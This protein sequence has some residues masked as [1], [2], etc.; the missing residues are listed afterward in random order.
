M[1]GF[2]YLTCAFLAS[3]AF[4][5]ELIEVSLYTGVPGLAKLGESYTTVTTNTKHKYVKFPIEPT[6]ELGKLGYTQEFEFKQLGARV[7]FKRDGVGMITLQEPFKGQI[8]GKKIKLFS[9]SPPPGYNWET[10]L[11][12]EFGEPEARASGGKLGSNG[13]FYNWGDVSYNRMGPN[14]LSLYRNKE[15]QEYRLKNFGRDLVLYP[16]PK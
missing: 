2:V 10:Q 14:Q 12:K 3:A 11:E 6:S 8:K 5:I 15:L 9:I 7:Y 1:K 4:S 13:M 16:Q